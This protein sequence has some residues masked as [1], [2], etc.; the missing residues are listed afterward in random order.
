MP[1]YRHHELGDLYIALSVNFPDALDESAFALLEQA[2]PPRADLKP[3]AFMETEE[4]FMEE[5]DPNK[6]RRREDA[7]D[8]DDGQPQGGESNAASMKNLIAD[9]RITSTVQCAQQ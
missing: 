8:E 2:L 4:V 3:A 1:S 7:M 9:L 5:P 6:Q